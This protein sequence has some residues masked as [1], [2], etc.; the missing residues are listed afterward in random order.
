MEFRRRNYSAELEF[1]ALPRV[2]AASHPLSASPPP[3]P[4]AQVDVVDRGN[5]DF[6]D[7]LRGNDNDA[8]AAPPDHDNLN[9]AAD[10]QPTKEWTSFRRLLMQRFP[11]SKMVSVSTMV[12]VVH[13]ESMS[14]GETG[15]VLIS[16]E[17]S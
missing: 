8:N 7:P 4:L 9:E 10:H 15:D 12:I 17:R 6:F 16:F 2:H 1:H 3:P 14:F 13:I 11:V 5:N